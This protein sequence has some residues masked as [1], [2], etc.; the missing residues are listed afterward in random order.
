M[1]GGGYALTS[2]KVCAHQVTREVLKK[3]NK[4]RKCMSCGQTVRDIVNQL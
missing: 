3:G 2:F 1:K 4:T